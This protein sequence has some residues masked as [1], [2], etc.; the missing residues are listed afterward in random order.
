MEPG[1][2]LQYTVNVPKAGKYRLELE[3][4]S[5]KEDGKFYLS[6]ENKKVTQSLLVPKLAGPQNIGV[7]NIKLKK[8]TNTLRL[9]VEAGGF[10]FSGIKFIAE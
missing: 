8:G 3:V 10:N 1:E 9:Y 4:T 2:W 6:L 7:G 5:A